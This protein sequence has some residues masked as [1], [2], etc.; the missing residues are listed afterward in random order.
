MR[1]AT[2]ALQ[3][4]VASADT[5]ALTAIVDLYT[6][7]LL[8]G[9]TIRVTSWDMALTIPA[10]NFPGSPFNF[11]NSGLVTFNLGPKFGRS[12]VST[13]VGVDPTEVDITIFA[14]PDDVLPNSNLSWQEALLMGQ[15]DGATVELDRFFMPAGSDGFA[16]PVST[17]LGAI[18]WF[19][20]LVAD[21]D[22][23]RSTLNIKVK[24]LLNLVARQQLPR[25]LF[26]SGCN[27]IFGDAMCGYNR[28]LGKNAAGASTGAGAITVTAITG[29]SPT[30]IVM[31]SGVASFFA[32]GTAIGLTGANAGIARGIISVGIP[33]IVGLALAFP[34]NITPGD[35]FQLLPGCDHNVTGTCQ[36]TFNNLPQFGGDPF[37]PPPELAY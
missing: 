3:N 5:A 14:G 20:G 36:T 13:K 28:V 27:H 33:T 15:F 8:G 24:S 29:S 11:A 2:T 10:T 22:S 17:T 12:K 18:V 35:T 7:Q 37:I 25:R 23:G 31:G 1:P 4:Y 26:Q 6:I 9:A 21:V 16:G 30:D 34:N 32:F 19:Y